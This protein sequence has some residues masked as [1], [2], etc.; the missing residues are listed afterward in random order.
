MAAFVLDIW[1]PG[2]LHLILPAMGIVSEVIPT[3]CKPLFGYGLVVF[4]NSDRFYGVCGL[5][6]SY[7]Y[8]GY[9]C[10]RGCCRFCADCDTNG[11]KIF[12]WIGTMWGRIRF[13]NSHAFRPWI[14]NHVHDRWFHWNHAFSVPIDAQHQ[15][16][17]FVVAHF[18]DLI[19]GTF[20]FVPALLLA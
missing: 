11:V 3:F 20:R 15:D 5:E 14:H 19:G 9:G 6:P 4:S 8:Y 7:V 10:G 2:S 1:A 18:L 12:N 13:G 17:Y 16:T